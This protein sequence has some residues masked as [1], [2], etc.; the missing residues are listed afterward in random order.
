MFQLGELGH[1][2]KGGNCPPL[3]EA[4][5]AGLCH[6]NIEGKIVLSTGAFCPRNIPGAMLVDCIEEWHCRNPNQ[7]VKGQ[8][9]SNMNTSQMMYD[10]IKVAKSL[11]T[12]AVGTMRLTSKDRI[13]VLEQELMVL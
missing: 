8:L 13:A 9:S 7:I 5:K 10:C 1:T 11:E 12:P 6:Q 3:E 2:V 4:I